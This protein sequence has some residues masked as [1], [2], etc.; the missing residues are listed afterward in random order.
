MRHN[1]MQFIMILAVAFCATSSYAGVTA[2]RSADAAGDMYMPPHD[3]K[4]KKAGEE[5]KAASECQSHH[6]CVK[7][8]KKRVCQAPE[9]VNIP[10]T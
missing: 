4:K 8:N 3:P 1:L 5:C 7:M 10:N 2:K 6:E 9:P